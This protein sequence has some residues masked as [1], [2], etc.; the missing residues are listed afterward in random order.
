M[1][2]RSLPEPKSETIVSAFFAVAMQAPAD[3]PHRRVFCTRKVGLGICPNEL[4]KVH[5]NNWGFDLR[6]VSS[7]IAE[8]GTARI[9]APVAAAGQFGSKFSRGGSLQ[10]DNKTTSKQNDFLTLMAQTFRNL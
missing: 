3:T 7:A 10:A 5:D 4:E 8:P 1:L 9:S 2:D 6:Q